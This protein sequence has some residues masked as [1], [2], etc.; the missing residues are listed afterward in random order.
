MAIRIRADFAGRS[1]ARVNFEL[2]AFDP[3]GTGIRSLTVRGN[4]GMEV[5]LDPPV[6]D[7]ACPEIWETRISVLRSRLPLEPEA[8]DCVGTRTGPEE[9]GLIGEV[10]FEPGIS[11][12][13]LP[14]SA[15]QAE[16]CGRDTACNTAQSEAAE[17]RSR[18]GVLC[19]RVAHLRSLLVL[20]A[21]W[22]AFYY[23]AAIAAFIGAQAVAGIPFAGAVLAAILIAAGVAALAA[24]VFF[25]LDA[26][27]LG[28]D[29]RQ[30]DAD[31]QQVAG[32][33]REA[34]A[35]VSRRCCRQCILIDLTPP[36]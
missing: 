33:F 27:R 32:A 9:L 5:P 23:A 15:V 19:D 26:W 35:E 1:G 3:D 16:D 28:N 20:A 12:G 11:G 17:V 14:C 13:R 36:C 7:Q 21:F 2:M 29:L 6:P 8:M 31:R 34:A 4:D 22:A 30:M 25:A 10:G 18:L 24:S